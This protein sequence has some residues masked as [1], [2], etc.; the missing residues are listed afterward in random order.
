[1]LKPLKGKQQEQPPPTNHHACVVSPRESWWKPP[2]ACLPPGGGHTVTCS[3]QRRDAFI[4]HVGCA[5]GGCR[6]RG[7]YRNTGMGRRIASKT[8]ER[9]RHSFDSRTETPS[10]AIV[11]PVG[12]AET[13]GGL[14]CLGDRRLAQQAEKRFE[15]KPPTHT[16]SCTVSTACT[17][18]TRNIQCL[19]ERAKISHVDVHERASR[20]SKWHLP[21][22]SNPTR[23]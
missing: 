2:V 8:H 19:G 21:N 6:G 15:S 11:Y 22:L 23:A 4:E 5:G 16:T 20:P 18:T 13:I 3:H 1:M 9:A 14:Y 10:V 7:K 17:R 12:N